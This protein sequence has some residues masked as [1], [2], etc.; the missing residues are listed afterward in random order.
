M[1][2][3]TGP[4]QPC[5]S[6]VRLLALRRVRRGSVVAHGDEL[7]TDVGHKIPADVQCHLRAL[8]AEGYLELD[9][10]DTEGDQH[11]L[12]VTEIGL[13]LYAALEALHPRTG[14]EHHTIDLARVLAGLQKL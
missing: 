11:T 13:L 12:G 1:T 3:P 14:H 4:A 2:G 9:G 6:L 5:P 10:P 8:L 7:F